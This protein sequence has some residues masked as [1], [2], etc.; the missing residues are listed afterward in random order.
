MDTD[1]AREVG[2]PQ[3]EPTTLGE[4]N[5]STIAI[6]NKDCNGQKTKHIEIRFNLI[7]EQVKKLVI[8]LQHLKTQGMTSGILTKPSDSKP[9]LHLRCKL[10]SMMVLAA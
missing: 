3:L 1:A 10:L 9:F 8:E 2:H 7:R 5:M 6:I 4:D